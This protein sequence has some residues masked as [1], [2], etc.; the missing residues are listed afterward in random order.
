MMV[1]AADLRDVA[2]T[3]RGWVVRSWEGKPAMAAEYG[4]NEMRFRAVG[5]TFL[6]IRIATDPYVFFHV[7]ADGRHIRKVGPEEQPAVVDVPV[8]EGG[9]EVRLLRTAVSSGPFYVDALVVDFEA[10]DGVRFLP[11]AEPVPATVFSTFGDSISGNCC[12]GDDPPFDPHGLGYGYT[13]CKRFGWQYLNP[14]RDGSGVC[15]R[16]FGNPLAE[17][18]LERDLLRHRPDVVLIFYGTND[19]RASISVE[20]FSRKF[21]RLVGLIVKGLPG[22]RIATSGLLWNDMS[23]PELIG[24]YNE[25]IA[26]ISQRH[27]LPHA[28][29]FEAV[30]RADIE[31][32][33]HPNAEGQRK[34]G[35]FFTRFFLGTWPDLQETLHG[36]ALR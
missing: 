18:R 25:A 3:G 17:E 19:I 34:L 6:R 28:A 24:G 27:G 10:A 7:Y 22:S 12:I 31:D 32:G 11:P 36:G 33:V 8:A 14:A 20:E 35:E 1:R 9:T 13:L 26:G 15:C 21:D 16:P 5:T 2:S 23:P 30:P 29:P 4:G